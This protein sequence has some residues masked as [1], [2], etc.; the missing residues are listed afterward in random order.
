M[1]DENLEERKDCYLQSTKSTY[2][3]VVAM[4]ERD[5]EIKVIR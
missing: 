4:S 1:V 5:F 2:G 3:M